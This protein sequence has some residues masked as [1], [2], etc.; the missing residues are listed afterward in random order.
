[1]SSYH[2]ERTRLSEDR[3]HRIAELLRLGYTHRQIGEALGI[4]GSAVTQH[5][6]RSPM[7]RR[8]T[9]SRSGQAKLG[10]LRR[11]LATLIDELRL[12]QR[13]AKQ[14]L[15]ELDEELDSIALDRD[16]GLR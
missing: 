15:R 1:M 11:E 13:D 3:E 4:T 2:A 10:A 8:L 12:M 7:L 14:A 9:R 5:V 6:G 16:L